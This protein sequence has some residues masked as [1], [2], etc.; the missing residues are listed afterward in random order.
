MVQNVQIGKSCRVQVY[1]PQNNHSFVIRTQINRYILPEGGGILFMGRRGILILT[2]G[3]TGGVCMALMF[4]GEWA[5]FKK[6]G[7]LFITRF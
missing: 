3:Y 2:K 4:V 6:S 5:R 7:E 1:L